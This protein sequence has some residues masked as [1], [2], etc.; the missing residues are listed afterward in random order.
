MYKVK[1]ISNT[2]NVLLIF[3]FTLQGLAFEV[4]VGTCFPGIEVPAWFNHK[5][6]GAVIKPELPRHWSESGFVGIA[7]CAIVSFHDYKIQNNNL[8]VKCMHM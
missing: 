7:L 5:A 6:S 3:G 2:V 1:S 8:I 4:L